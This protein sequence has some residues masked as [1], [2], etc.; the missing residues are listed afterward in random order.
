M[1]HFDLASKPKIISDHFSS[2]KKDYLIEN[3]RTSKLNKEL[4]KF[5][6]DNL[7]EII[8]GLPVDIQKLNNEFKSLKSYSDS[9]NLQGK[10]KAIFNYKKFRDKSVALYDAYDLANSLGVRTCLYCNRMYTITISK[11]RKTN[12]KITRPQFD[13]FFDKAKNPLLSLSIYNLIPSCNICNSTLKGTKEFTLKSY[14][15]PYVNNYINQYNFRFIPHDVS[16]ILGQKSNLEVE[17]VIHSRDL[18]EYAKIK[19]T[20]DLFRL[21]DIMSG[22]SEELK[23]LFDIR[24]KFSQRY[25]KELFEAYKKLGLSYDEVYRILFG[26]HFIEDKFNQ[27]PFSKLKKD[28]LKELNII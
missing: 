28:I 25:F 20:S 22:H 18:K 3:I 8:T 12:E 1:I 27:R 17:I 14:M 21:S 4:K 7:Y 23:D 15:H 11:G 9:E 6:V 16:S 13:H 24:Y 26:V 10:I 19:K 5:I 2:L